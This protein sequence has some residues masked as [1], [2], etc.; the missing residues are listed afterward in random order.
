MPKFF[1]LYDVL[2]G[3]CPG[4]RARQAD[5]G[6]GRR[7]GTGRD[8]EDLHQ[9]RAVSRWPSQTSSGHDGIERALR[10]RARPLRREPDLVPVCADRAGDDRA[11]RGLARAVRL[12]GLS[13]LPRGAFGRVTDFGGLANY[14]ALLT[15]AR[16]W[17]AF[18]VAA[19]FVL[20]AVP[21]E[22]MLGLAGALVL[23]QRIRGRRRSSCRC[24][25]CRP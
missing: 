25:S 13:Q 2:S 18:G 21:I 5:A 7:K 1:E 8:A 15:N 14:A 24:C 17:N 9:M 6:G 22:F 23:N 11:G 3:I 20:I 16:F 19:L 12:R 10:G 4:D